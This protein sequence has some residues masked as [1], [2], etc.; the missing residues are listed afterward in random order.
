MDL[1]MNAE[2]ITSIEDPV[3][4]VKVTNGIVPIITD[5]EEEMQTAIL[6]GFIE[7]NTIPQLPT[8]GVPWQDY[9]TGTITFG[10]LDALV[11][12]SI[13]NAGASEFYPRYEITNDKLVM[14]IGREE[15]LV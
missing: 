11:R 8:A 5:Q 6:A 15:S 14:T 13:Q 7:Q 10:E 12:E 9:L 2:K 1:K 4:D 3:W